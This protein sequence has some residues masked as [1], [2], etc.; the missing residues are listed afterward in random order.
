MGGISR[1]TI[2]E[3]LG[4]WEVKKSSIS[5]GTFD[6]SWHGRSSAYRPC[7]EPF[8]YDVNK[9]YQDKKSTGDPR[10]GKCGQGC[11]LTSTINYDK[12]D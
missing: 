5:N 1:S 12:T 2:A 10:M 9:S 7:G 4:L 8:R 3:S 6:P 11:F